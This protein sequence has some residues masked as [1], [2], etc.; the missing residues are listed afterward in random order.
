MPICV[1]CSSEVPE[2]E[3][4]IHQRVAAISD[5]RIMDVAIDIGEP[6]TTSEMAD[7]FGVGKDQMSLRL[8]S[9]ATRG[10]LEKTG[11]F[12]STRYEVAP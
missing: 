12:G 2:P 8:N 3:G 4:T 6:F 7:R 1:Q 11:R 10:L 9:L 5:A